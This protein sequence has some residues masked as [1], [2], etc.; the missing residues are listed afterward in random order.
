MA[1]LHYMKHN[2]GVATEQIDDFAK[3]YLTEDS[4]CQIDELLEL[5]G[6]EKFDQMI[7]DLDELSKSV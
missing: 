4:L 1:S 2:N 7:A 3:K 6:D 5:W